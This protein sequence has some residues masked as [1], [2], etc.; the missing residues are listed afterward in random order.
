MPISADDLKAIEKALGDEG[1]E[2]LGRIKASQT[3][4]A[5]ALDGLKGQLKTAEKA[6]GWAERAAQKA[7]ADLEAASKGEGEQVKTLAAERDKAAADLEAA[8]V[9]HRQYR[10]ETALAEKLGITDTVRRRAAMKTL[11][12]PEGVD[13]DDN[14]DLLGADP[15][16]EGFKKSHAFFFDAKT[17]GHGGP[18]PG[19]DPPPG[20]GGK[21]KNEAEEAFAF[22][23]EAVKASMSRSPFQIT[24]AGGQE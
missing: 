22:G 9:Q 20:G 10:I 21:P 19:A 4:D 1:T 8:Q 17:P 24:A 12:V 6:K 3:E 15:H 23:R 11:G 7:A 16:V 5:T 2:L 18:P 14:G 13:L